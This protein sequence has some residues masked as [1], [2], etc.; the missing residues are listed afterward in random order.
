MASGPRRLI[1]LKLA[2][3]TLG[4]PARVDTFQDRLALQKATYLAQAAGLQLGY[5]YS[6]YL[7]G[8]YSPDLT[9]D[10]FRLVEDPAIG[11]GFVLGADHLARLER[12]AEV[13]RPA[14]GA[15]LERP[16]WLE[17]LASLHYLIRTLRKDR[18]GAAAVIRRA[19]PHLAGYIDE[20]FSALATAA[21]I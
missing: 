21:L 18:E 6:W 19:K 4:V 11:S 8:P 2:L 10:Y 5:R 7:K 13:A 15:D 14:P 20:G 3:D 12:L 16:E 9:R 17:L 1:G